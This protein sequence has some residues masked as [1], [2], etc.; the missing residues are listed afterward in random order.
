ME[1]LLDSVPSPVGDLMP[2]AR[3]GALVALEIGGDERRLR[4][5]LQ[6]RFGDP[7]L[8]RHG[9]PFGFSSRVRAYLAGDLQALD[10]I[11]VDAGGTDFQRQVWAALRRVPAGTTTSYGQLAAA[12]GR[13]GAARAVGL[14]N[15]QNPVAVVVP[16][17][18]V[19]GADGSLTGYAG[20]LHRKRWLLQ[21]EGV[22]LREAAGAQPALF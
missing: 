19:I 2:V 3:D 11:P 16:C 14:A 6:A 4:V 17:H 7:T 22:A 20:G 1:L 12:L 8:V 21:H 13:P 18:R 10:D 9:D 15:A 5:H